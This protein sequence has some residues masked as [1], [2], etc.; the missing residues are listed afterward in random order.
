MP[1]VSASKLLVFS[2][3][4]A[5]ID[6]AAY[7]SFGVGVLSG[8]APTDPVPNQLFLQGLEIHLTGIS[9]GL[10][11]LDV[12]I[13]Y[14]SAGDVICQPAINTTITKGQTTNTKASAFAS[15]DTGIVLPPAYQNSGVLYVWV[16][17]HE[18]LATATTCQPRLFGGI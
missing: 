8:D 18:A 2:A 17:P 12:K 13:T 1:C 7:T 15:I 14:D 6:N 9:A 4:P 11:S 3:S 10:T 16:K 5:A